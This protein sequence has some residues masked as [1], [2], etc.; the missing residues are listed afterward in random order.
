MLLVMA[1]TLVAAA[2]AQS[3]NWQADYEPTM[4]R[5]IKEGRPAYYCVVNAQGQGL[6][7][8]SR[9][10]FGL[11]VHQF[12]QSAADAL[13]RAHIRFVRTTMYWGTIENTVEPGK[14]DEAEL[15]HWDQTVDL[16]KKNDMIPVVV[17]H[18][19]APGASFANRAQSYKRFADFMAFV[20]KRYPYV[21]YWELWNEMDSD[22]TDLFGAKVKSEVPM[23]QR[24]GYYAEMLKIAY[25]AIKEANPKAVVL[26]GGSN[27]EEFPVGIYEGGGKDYFDVMSIHTYGM[28]LQWAFVE[29]GARVREIM[30]KYG[31]GTKPL[32]NTEF[33]VEAGSYVQAWGMPKPPSAAGAAFD[34]HQKDMISDCI[35]FNLQS[36]LYQ[37]CFA[38]QYLAG[39]EAHNEEIKKGMP[40]GTDVDDYG[41]GFMR[42]DGVTPKP[43][44]QYILNTDPNGRANLAQP[45]KV[46]LPEAAGKEDVV[47]AVNSDYPTEIH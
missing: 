47:I 30:K 26:T 36:G 18:S 3:V 25:P 35:E 14:Y 22:F 16:F 29:R 20:A 28:P 4:A 12:D 7:F 23:R 44:M 38:Y 34:K 9:P 33:G 8:D 31:D 1:A 43:V 2:A 21:R 19:N 6:V 13:K 40:P 37:K 39:N 42:K 11:G 15:R 24:G 27:Y 41:G 10:E 17:V 32:W 5:L 45:V 46:K